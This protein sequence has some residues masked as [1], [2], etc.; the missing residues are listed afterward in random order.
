MTYTG[1]IEG[2]FGRLL[3]WEQ[4]HGILKK[5]KSLGLNTYLYGPKEDPYHRLQWRKP[6]PTARITELG[7]FAKAGKRNGITV[8]AAVAP[9]LSYDYLSKNDYKTLLKK[10]TALAGAGISTLALH[11][12]DIPETLPASCSTSFHSLGEAHGLL[13]GRLLDDLHKI[14]KKIRLWFCPTIYTDE[15]IRVNAANTEY[16]KD[17]VRTMPDSIQTLWTGPQ[18]V[19]KELTADNLRH[20]T[21]AFNNRI[22]LWDNYYATDYCPYRIFVGPYLGREH[23]ILKQCSGVMINPTGLYIT[24]MLLLSLFADFI[25]TG[26]TSVLAWEKRAEEFG[27]PKEFYPFRNYFWSP[28]LKPSENDLSVEEIQNYI[29]LNI[30][31]T[32]I[33]PWQDQL[34]RE[35]FPYLQGL[36]RDLRYVNNNYQSKGEDWLFNNYP[37]ILAKRLSNP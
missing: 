1:Y 27:V 10:F 33:V 7:A 15:F 3:T 9:G 23:R 13:L 18:V 6:Y 30:Y 28:F 35:W 8:I 34:K 19:A 4:R 17:L 25:K 36:Q 31:D 16:I 22:V 29:S 26:D 21:T 37:P 5:M 32:L 12:D 24:D 11:M 14:S 2:Y 20:I